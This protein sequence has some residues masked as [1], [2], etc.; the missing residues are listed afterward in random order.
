MRS[1]DPLTGRHLQLCGSELLG[2]T[3]IH[4]GSVVL[5]ISEYFAHSMV[6]P[7]YR[8]RTLHTPPIQ[9]SCNR[10]E[11]HP[12]NDQHLID[13]PHARDFIIRAR[14]KNH[15]ICCEALSFTSS[16]LLLG[17]SIWRQEQSSQ[18]VAC[19]SAGS[20]SK[21][22]DPFLSGKGFESQFAAVFSSHCSLESLHDDAGCC[23]IISEGF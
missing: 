3:P 4:N 23:S 14:N 15:P 13:L 6:G 20:K 8:I 1:Y 16:E 22:S 7:A 11:S 17:P 9:I 10:N 18:A 12:T 21:F 5:T 19:C 2:S